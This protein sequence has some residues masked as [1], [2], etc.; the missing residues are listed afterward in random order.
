MR[1]EGCF[2][3]VLFL[4]FVFFSESHFV[5]SIFASSKRVRKGA[6]S[7]T[8]DGEGHISS[9]VLHCCVEDSHLPVP[10][11]P[12]IF[13]VEAGLEKGSGGSADFPP[14]NHA[15]SVKGFKPSVTCYSSQ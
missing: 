1:G 12:D 14:L 9:M 7:K 2:G 6:P 3:F 11:V 5:C 8:S 10:V 13:Q 4:L 15:R